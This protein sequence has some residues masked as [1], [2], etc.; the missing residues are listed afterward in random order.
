MN[1]DSFN[2][3][4]VP[5]SAVNLEIAFSNIRDWARDKTGR[6]ICVRD[7]ASLMAITEHPKFSHLHNK[8]SMITPD[9][10]PLVIIG[11]LRGQE[12]SRTCGPDLMAYSC[13][14]SEKH[15]LKHYFYGGK[16]GVA[17]AVAKNFKSKYPELIVVGAE[18][19]P[20]RE[21]NEME[22]PETIERL[23]N[24]GADIIWLGL[25]SPKQDIWM[26]NHYQKLPQTIIGV[27]AAFDFHAGTV[28]R[29]PILMQKLCLE[30][31]FRFLQEPRRLYSRYLIAA[32]KFVFKS[33]FS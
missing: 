14:H 20:M 11:K 28:K 27:G 22:P 31:L 6:F 23:R 32:P 30:W 7:V 1:F 19:P 33:I 26:L 17:E 13:A 5:I 4:G 18:A 10:M 3:L 24:S 16:P 15:G 25:S 8:A 21:E 29:A 2:V 12:V 9:G